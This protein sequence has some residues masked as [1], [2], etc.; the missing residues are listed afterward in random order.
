MAAG[1]IAKPS[2]HGYYNTVQ[3]RPSQ[4][5]AFLDYPK[6]KSNAWCLKEDPALTGLNSYAKRG[7]SHEYSIPSTAY[8]FPQ[9]ELAFEV[10]EIHVTGLQLHLHHRRDLQPIYTI[11]YDDKIL[12]CRE[13]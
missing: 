10:S 13:L 2:D 4:F 11:M 9:K 5:P 6:S 8:F 1:T 7:H 12:N 3:L